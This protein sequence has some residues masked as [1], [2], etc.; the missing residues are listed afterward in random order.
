MNQSSDLSY[1]VKWGLIIGV[2]YIGLLY[3][4]YASAASHPILMSLLTLVGFVIVVGLLVA[5]GVGLR[6]KNGGYLE[7]KEA[8]K[9]LFLAVLIYEM[10]YSVFSFIYLKYVDPNFFMA[11]RDNMVALMKQSGQPQ[12]KIDE[13][14][15]GVD[16]NAGRDMNIFDMLKGYLV[17]ISVSGIIALITSLA[18][19][20][21]SPNQPKANSFS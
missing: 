11:F 21:K 1:G 8:F 13:I 15:K 2:A 12:A 5:C 14:S 6:K 10:C 3:A 17:G 7:V 20:K 16:V 9:V 19:R 18:L 4:R